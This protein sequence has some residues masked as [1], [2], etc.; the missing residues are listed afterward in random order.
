METS[1]LFFA[2][3][4]PPDAHRCVQD[5]VGTTLAH[6]AQHDYDFRDDA[7]YNGQYDQI[8]QTISTFVPTL[9]IRYTTGLE[10]SPPPPHLPPRSD[11]N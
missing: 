8:Y 7:V 9:G 3:A 10:E 2:A 4:I 11:V 5:W 6:D 1:G